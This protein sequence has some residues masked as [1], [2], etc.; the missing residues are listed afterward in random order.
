MFRLPSG[1]GVVTEVRVGASRATALGLLVGREPTVV[2]H[3]LVYAKSLQESW[4]SVFALRLDG[5][6]VEDQVR[7]ERNETYKYNFCFCKEFVSGSTQDDRASSPVSLPGGTSHTPDHTDPEVGR[8]IRRVVLRGHG[9]GPPCR[10]VPGCEW[11]RPDS[12]IMTLKG[13]TNL[14]NSV[15]LSDRGLATRDFKTS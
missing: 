1:H 12:S 8:K 3:D 4:A 11:L 5:G 13:I 6:L 10:H 7:P 2:V 9:R 15:H 14:I